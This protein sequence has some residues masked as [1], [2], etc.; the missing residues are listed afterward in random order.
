MTVKRFVITVALQKDICL[1][2]KTYPKKLALITKSKSVFLEA[3]RADLLKE[4]KY[5]LRLT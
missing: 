2:G 5:N 4:L 1:Q 3:H